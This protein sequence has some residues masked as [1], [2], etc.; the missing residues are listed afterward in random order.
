[1][2]QIFNTNIKSKLQRKFNGVFKLVFLLIIFSYTTEGLC[3]TIINDCGFDMDWNFIQ[4]NDQ[5]QS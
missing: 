3:Q 4:N 2:K 5:E 1:M